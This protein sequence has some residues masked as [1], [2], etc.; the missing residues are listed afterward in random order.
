MRK[1]LLTI[2]SVAIFA[3]LS[4]GGY[5]GTLANAAPCA[6]MPVTTPCTNA[7]LISDG[8]VTLTIVDVPGDGIV[9]GT[10]LFGTSG[11]SAVELPKNGNYMTN[12]ASW[13][14]VVAPTVEEGYAV[15]TYTVNGDIEKDF[16]FRL[17]LDNSAKF[18]GN[19]YLDYSDVVPNMQ[20]G[21]HTPTK[22]CDSSPECSWEIDVVD[23]GAITHGSIFAIYYRFQSAQVLATPKEQINLRVQ[24]GTSFQKGLYDD[25]SIT[26]ASSEEPVE[27]SLE[28]AIEPDNTRISVSSNSTEFNSKTPTNTEYLDS[29]SVIIGYLSIKNKDINGVDIV[30]SDGFTPWNIGNIDTGIVAPSTQPIGSPDFGISGGTDE[31]QTIFTI[32]DGQFDASL[33]GS[34]GKLYFDAATD[35]SAN[36]VTVDEARWELTNDDIQKLVT[37]VVNINGPVPIVLKVDGANTINT[38][39]N[40]PSAEFLLNYA[41]TNATRDLAFSFDSDEL[42]KFRQDGT[43]CWVYN[44]PNPDASDALSIRITNESSS[45]GTI[46]AT[47]Y[48]EDGT[49]V[50]G[51]EGDF[52]LRNIISAAKPLTA[53]DPTTA[54]NELVPDPDAMIEGGETVRLSSEMVRDTEGGPYT[55]TARGS[56]MVI[57][58]TLPN[59]QIMTL[60]RN[61]RTEF[62]PRP[63]TNL[64]L[65]THHLACQN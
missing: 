35:I 22:A 40:A 29:R 52:Q 23:G 28:P 45:P 31:V 7:A 55:W 12:A 27:I 26:V 3:T 18:V 36:E 47:F 59:I 24:M 33:T 57:T 38:I 43:V 46:Q 8:A 14:N 10:H 19:V 60:L 49:L 39:E 44:V 48:N 63:L 51:S 32:F 37:E 34:S 4:Q 62:E 21:V 16:T 54:T 56:H 9:Y 1:R 15:A 41:E 50:T 58:T 30:A 42:A 64:S 13:P 25:R 11:G 6:A 65:G 5:A 17:T 20:G 2:L 61:K 53:D